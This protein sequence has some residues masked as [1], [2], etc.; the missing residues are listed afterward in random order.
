V[1]RRRF[2]LPVAITTFALATIGLGSVS[3]SAATEASGSPGAVS[4]QAQSR[5]D[6]V[7]TARNTGSKIWFTVANG[8][9][10]DV[11]APTVDATNVETMQ[12]LVT[13]GSSFADLQ[14]RD[15]TYTVASDPTGMTCTVTSTA[16]SGAYRL[17]TTYLTDPARDSVVVNTKYVALTKS[18]RTYALY[19]RLDANAGGN[20]G[21]GSANGGADNAVVDTSTGSP[22]PVTYDTHTTSQANRTAYAVPSFLA[23]R[24]NQPFRRNRQ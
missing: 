20:G 5:K 22:V 12:F 10:S 7:G 19:L 17:V 15:T 3:A 18:A 9:L 2:V 13:D 1:I 14:E 4:H 6:C 16:K 21:G 8:I 24:A 11:Y 23:L